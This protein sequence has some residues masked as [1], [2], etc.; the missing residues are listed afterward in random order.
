MKK[1]ETKKDDALLSLDDLI[2]DGSLMKL[3]AKQVTKHPAQPTGIYSLDKAL[4]I[5]GLPLSR[6][7][8]VFGPTGGGKTTLALMLIAAIQKR[9]GDCVYIDAEHALDLAY[10]KQ[11]GVDIDTLLLSQPDSAEGSL[12]TAQNVVE[13]GVDLLI[14]D[15]VAALTP[16]V[17]IDGDAT[18][19]HM[20]VH[21]RLMN[22]L[23]RK[24]VATLAVHKSKTIILLINQLRMKL[25]IMFGNPETTTGGKGIPFFACVR[26]DIRPSTAIKDGEVQIG[27]KTKFKIIKNKVAPPYKE[28]EVDLIFGEGFDN[29]GCLLDAAVSA[30]IVEKS[31]AWFSYKGERLGQGR[32]NTKSL[33][34][35]NLELLNKIEE[36]LKAKETL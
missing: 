13:C 17:E 15:S 26:I 11:L 10:A 12:N 23:C 1:K 4:G 30:E 36:E 20:G 19:S 28:C 16:Q 2:N 9:G 34:K 7:V 31:G 6:I 22:K 18:E 25:G 21:A 29:V 8:E 24:L 5:G 27:Q 14:I 32:D 33:L 3:K 35:N